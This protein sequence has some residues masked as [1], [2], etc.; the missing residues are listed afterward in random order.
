[1]NTNLMRSISLI[2]IV[3][4]ICFFLFVVKASTENLLGIIIPC[5]VILSTFI[6]YNG[7]DGYIIDESGITQ[8]NMFETNY[9]WNEIEK[10]SVKKDS[11]EY[12]INNKQYITK[13]EEKQFD[14]IV[15]F[16]NSIGKDYCA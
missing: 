8:P 9:D 10:I 16:L 4:T 3:A 7:F 12:V 11:I 13:I 5:Y 1:M 14:R 6:F 2:L 15:S